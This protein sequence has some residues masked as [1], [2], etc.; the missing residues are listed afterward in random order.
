MRTLSGSMCESITLDDVVNYYD[1]GD[2]MMRQLE[3]GC[4]PKPRAACAPRPVDPVALVLSLRA[5]GYTVQR[6]V[7]A[8]LDLH[9][10]ELSWEYVRSICAGRRGRK[11]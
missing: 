5:E 4:K 7:D 6:I 2:R 11:S 8:L 3:F 10:V 9:G 1:E